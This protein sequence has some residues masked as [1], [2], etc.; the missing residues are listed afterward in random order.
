[1]TGGDAFT[2]RLYL[3]PRTIG[4]QL[5]RIFPELDIT[6][7]TQLA[8][9]SISL[10][11]LSVSPGPDSRGAVTVQP[12]RQSGDGSRTPGRRSTM[13][14]NRDPHQGGQPVMTTTKAPVV[15]SHGLWLHASSWQ[16]WQE[17]FAEAGYEPAAPDW[18][19]DADTV[20]AS[21]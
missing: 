11:T 12:A 17:R 14:A 18:P 19:G 8:S 6:S 9:G 16:P 13:A 7:R 3:S 15:F 10:T 20:Q 5:Y 1:L 21:R 4:S 2:G